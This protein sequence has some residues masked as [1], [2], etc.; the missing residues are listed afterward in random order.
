[1]TFSSWYKYLLTCYIFVMIM[2]WYDNFISK[3]CQDITLAYNITLY[4]TFSFICYE[5]FLNFFVDI[6]Y[7]P[8]PLNSFMYNIEEPWVDWYCIL[9]LPSSLNCQVFFVCVYLR[10]GSISLLTAGDWTP[11][12]WIGLLSQCRKRESA[13]AVAGIVCTSRS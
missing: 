3:L 10:D 4:K 2:P 8:W 12:I 11:C 7:D 1:M 13:N 5:L 9:R 6:Q